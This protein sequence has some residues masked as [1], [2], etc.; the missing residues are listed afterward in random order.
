MTSVE[1]LFPLSSAVA[2]GISARVEM[3]EAQESLEQELE[4][5]DGG[6]STGFGSLAAVLAISVCGLKL[7][8]TKEHKA[9]TFLYPYTKISKKQ[10]NRDK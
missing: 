6:L 9:R 5:G 1:I 2:A 8:L 10:S 3:L 4:A 7:D